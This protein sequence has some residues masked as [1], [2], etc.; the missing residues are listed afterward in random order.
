M[1]LIGKIRKNSWLLIVLLAL[2]LGGFIL[3]DMVSAAQRRGNSQFTIGEVNGNKLE[4]QDFQ[5]AER[6]LY[7]N[8]GGDIYGQRNYLWSYML[9]EQLL[10]SEASAMGLNVGEEEMEELQFGQQLS[11]IIQRNFRDPN[12]GMVDRNNLN[13]IKANLGTGNLVPQLEEFWNFQTTEIVKDRLQSKL[14][15]LVK[16]SLYSPTWLASRLQEETGSAID[17]AYVRIPYDQVADIEVSLTDDDYKAWMKENEGLI[18][19]KEEFRS[20]DFVVFNV[21]PTAEDSAALYE[22]ISGL[23]EPFRTTDNDSQFVANHYGMMEATYYQKGDLPLS[24]ADTV[25]SLNV[26]DVYGPYMDNGTYMAVKVIDR[27]VIPDSVKSRHILIRAESA[28]QIQQAAMKIDSIKTLIEAG[29]AS[30]DSMAIKH[31]QDVSGVSGGDLGWSAPGR[32]V[33]PFNDVLFYTGKPGELSVVLT[34]FG[35]HLVDITGRKFESNETGIK[36]AFLAEPIIPSEETQQAVYDDALEFSGQN[37]TLEALKAAV[38]NNPELHLESA[39]ALTAN[40]YQFSSLG[41]G[42]TAREIVRWAF[43]KDTKVGTVAPEVYIFNE[44]TLFYDAQYVVPALRS[45]VKPG[46]A[47]VDEVKE[48]FK[49]QV[50]VRKKGEILTSKITSTDL[51]A[52]AREYGVSVDTLEGTNFGMNYLRNI[53]NENRLIGKIAHLKRGEVTKPVA[54]LSGVFVAKV[55][56]RTEASL[57]TDISAYRA[58]LNMQS[59]SA[60]DN[61]LM[62]AIKNAANIKDN[63]Y[64]FY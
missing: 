41:T 24:I 31:S 56:E 40:S 5:R 28:Q 38:A 26:G 61:R 47:T 39:E 10:K 44:P 15:N 45:V 1:A 43:S 6:I 58:Q 60:I 64:T 37:R 50:L 7:P 51:E 62:D 29:V 3:M 48:Y 49:Q 27:K 16:K 22:K 36:L 63:R 52:I 17:I 21:V 23:I 54:G 18:K 2:A 57:P 59:R 32:M 19:R 20:V 46:L 33:K 30:F 11:P 53:G 12:T 25:F 8:S 42:G 55:I 13:Q 14:T 4:W 35:V 34:Q 9:E